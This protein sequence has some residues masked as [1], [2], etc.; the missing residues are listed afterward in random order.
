[1]PASCFTYGSLMCEDIMTHVA[2]V[3]LDSSQATLAGHARHPVRGEHYPAIV[4]RAGARVEGRLYF[5]VDAAAFA[6]LDAFEGDLYLRSTVDVCLPDGRVVAAQ[7]YLLRPAHT[8]LLEPGEWDF[9][10]FLADGKTR[11]QKRYL[12]FSRL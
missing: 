9:A 12:G 6:R 4:P 11:F 8:G 5:A 7:A 10:A 2:G 3:A 1:M